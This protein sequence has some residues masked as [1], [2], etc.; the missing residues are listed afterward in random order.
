MEKKLNKIVSPM[1]IFCFAAMVGFTAAAFVLKQWYLAAGELFVTGV[2]GTVY[3]LRRRKRVSEIRR[4]VG[5]MSQNFDIAVN[6][7]IAEMPRA[8]MR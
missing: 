7:T 3:I 8:P 2:L 1:I 6:D 4:L 5:L